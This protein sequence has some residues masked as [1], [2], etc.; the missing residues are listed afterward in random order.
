MN[1]H[2]WLGARGTALYAS[3]TEKQAAGV[4]VCVS[5]RTY[6]LMNFILK[7]IGFS[8][9]FVNRTKKKKRVKTL[10]IGGG[11]AERGYL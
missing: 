3:L 6:R 5:F 4:C 11:T 7:P 1:G 9:V 8:V 10:Y 2:K